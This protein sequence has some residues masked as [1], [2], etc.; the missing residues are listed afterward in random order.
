MEEG[1][2]RQD[3]DRWIKPEQVGHFGGWHHTK[4]LMGGR[5]PSVCASRGSIQPRWAGR[6]VWGKE[7]PET[8]GIENKRVGI[9]D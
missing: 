7:Q 6:L 2:V 9:V 5:V 4:L 1:E 3:L 8:D